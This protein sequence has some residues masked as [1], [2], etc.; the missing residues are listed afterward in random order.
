MSLGGWLARA[1]LL[2]LASPFLEVW[3]GGLTFGW[4]IGVVILFVGMKIAARLTG[5]RRLEI[6]GPF[7]DSPQPSPLSLK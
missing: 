3:G 6:Y 7:N 5:G 2:G 1:A 4:L